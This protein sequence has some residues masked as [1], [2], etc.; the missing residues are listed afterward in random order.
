M[1]HPHGT[2][3]ATLLAN[4]IQ[5]HHFR[6]PELRHDQQ[7]WWRAGWLDQSTWGNLNIGDNQSIGVYRN[8][9]NIQSV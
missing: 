7:P 6:H 1:T 8:A 2:P 9:G 5:I 4:D 3:A